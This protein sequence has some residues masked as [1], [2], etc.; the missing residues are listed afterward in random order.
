MPVKFRPAGNFALT[1]FFIVL[2]VLVALSPL[3]SMMPSRRQRQIAK[4]RQRAAMCGVQVQLRKPPAPVAD[5]GLQP[6]YGRGRQRGDHRVAATAIYHLQGDSWISAAGEPCIEH[7][8]LF[9]RLPDGV[10]HVYEA[11]REVGLFWNERGEESDVERISQ[12][13]QQLLTNTDN[14]EN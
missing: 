9:K 1:Y 3:I 11:A 6:F 12:V 10:S 14:Q 7:N 13:L 4:L 5:S 2:V 8:D